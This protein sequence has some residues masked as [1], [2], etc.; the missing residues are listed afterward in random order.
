MMK[1]KMK[2][3]MVIQIWKNLI[4]HQ[5]KYFYLLFIIINKMSSSKSNIRFSDLINYA[6]GDLTKILFPY[7]KMQ[8]L[9]KL[10]L[11]SSEI[12]KMVELYITNQ[13]PPILS[14]PTGIRYNRATIDTIAENIND[15]CS[16][17][18]K[19]PH[20]CTIG[21]ECEIFY[22]QGR[23]IAESD[24]P[25]AALR[26]IGNTRVK[27]SLKVFFDVEIGD[28][29]DMFGHVYLANKIEDKKDDIEGLVQIEL[30]KL[31]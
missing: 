8:D 17:F 31:E 25:L 9:L 28:K 1:T 7:L 23:R 20:E 2:T 29:I 27:I 6:H 19:E 15:A 11:T 13:L 22:N 14:L 18:I 30:L 12:K 10:R 16:V 24:P 21:L 26:E 5:N 4:N 3:S